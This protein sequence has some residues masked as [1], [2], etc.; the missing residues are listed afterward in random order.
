VIRI[1][2]T[3]ADLAHVRIAARPVPLQELHAA[4]MMLTSPA[5]APLLF[6][7]WRSRAARLLPAA[8]LPL[9]DLVP[10]RYAPAFL[11]STAAS[12]GEGLEALRASDPVWVAAE[13]E[14]AY[15]ATSAA[16]AAPCWIKDLHRGAHDAWQP[17][18][19]AERAAFD[20]LVAPVWPLVQ[21]LHR[22]EFARHA[23]T[24]AHHGIS[25]ALSAAV[26]G[27]RLD[28]GIWELA[29]PTA[30][31]RRDV[32]AAG[33]GVLLLP[34]FHWTGGPLISDVPG[35]PVTVT[36]PAGPGLPLTSGAATTTE[37]A[38]TE[39]LGRTRLRILT[40]SGDGLNTSALA[41]RLG[42]SAAT[43]S[44][45]TAALRAAGLIIS[46][47]DGK[48]VI[49]HRTALGSLL[50]GAPHEPHSTERA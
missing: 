36:Y 49:H 1:H 37:H 13:L 25:H 29:T 24:A 11:D 5:Q 31:A 28:G 42:L 27:S 34:T 43:V 8:A 2:L 15:A 12:L 9:R 4:L 50:L 19:R 39:V 10:G 32:Q 30:T 20:A 33:R 23:T 48:A 3:P 44:V 18:M 16:T 41:R 45:H 7:R 22:A 47:R 6:G 14:L 17:V 46:V 38:L 26:P 35:R 21:D 40:V